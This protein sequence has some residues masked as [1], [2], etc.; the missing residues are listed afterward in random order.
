[1]LDA[2]VWHDPYTVE[3]RELQ[4][5]CTYTVLGRTTSASSQTRRLGAV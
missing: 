2:G 4:L 3:M 1:M 5:T